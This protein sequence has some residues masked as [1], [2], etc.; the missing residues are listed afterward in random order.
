MQFRLI[1]AMSTV[2]VM[3]LGMPVYAA[4]ELIEEELTKISNLQK[5]HP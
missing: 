3:F 2:L 5:N 4:D 1:C